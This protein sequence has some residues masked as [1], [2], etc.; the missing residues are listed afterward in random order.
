MTVVTNLNS[1]TDSYFYTMFHVNV[2]FVSLSY[3]ILDF[4]L[5]TYPP[6]KMEQS[7]PKR[8]HTK[9]RRRGITQKKAYTY[10]IIYYV[11]YTQN[12]LETLAVEL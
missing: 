4:K 12:M 10:H 6:M 7:V 1:F 9:F 11:L 2:L 5:H 3:Y 8:R